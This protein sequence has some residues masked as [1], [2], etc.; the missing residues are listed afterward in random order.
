MKSAQPVFE[1]IKPPRLTDLGH[2]ALVKF[3][4]DRWQYEERIWE[5]CIG[6][7]EAHD[8]V[9][10]SIKSPMEPRILEHLAH[11]EFRTTVEEVTEVRLQED[12]KRRVGTLMNDHVPDVTGL[13][14]NSLKMDMK[15]ADIQAR[16]VKYFMDF[17]QLADDHG[18]MA[19]VGRGPTLSAL[20][21]DDVALYEL[22]VCRAKYQQHFHTMQSELKR[23]DPPKGKAAASTKS[24]NK[25]QQQI[26]T[27]G[28]AE[29]YKSE[30]K[31]VSAP[32]RTVCLVC[33]GPH[34]AKDSPDASEEMKQE[35]QRELQ[36]RRARKEDRAKTVRTVRAGEGRRVCVNGVL[37]VP[38]CPDTEELQGVASGVELEALNPV[39][40]VQVAGGAR[41][42]C[43]DTVM[44]DLRIETAAGPLHLTNVSCL[45]MDGHEDEFLLGRNTMQDIGIDIRLF[46][47]LAGGH[48][49]DANDDDVS[50]DIP[51]LAPELLSDLRKLIYEYAD[52][53]R[54]RI[55]ADPPADVEP[56]RV[57]LRDDAVPYRSG[58]KKY[59]PQQRQFFFREFV[60]ELEQHGLVR[61]N[62]ASHWA[63][64]ALPVKKP[65]SNEFRC[66]VDYRTPNKCTVPLPGA[67]PN[68]SSAT[69]SVKGA[70]GFGLV[71][72]FKG[73][74]QLPLRPDSQELFSFVT[75]DGVFTPTRLPQGTTTSRCIFSY[76]CNTEYIANVRTFLEVVRA[77]RL[78]LNAKKCVLF[79]TGVVWCGKVIDGQGV[80]HT[81][82]RLEALTGMA[83]PPTAA[84]LQQFLCTANWLRESMVDCARVVGPLQS[85]LEAVMSRRGRRKAQLTGVTLTWPPEDEAAFRAVVDLLATSAKLYFADPDAVVRDWVEGVPVT[86]QLHELLVC[87]GGLFTGSQVNW[88]IVEKEAYPVVRACSDLAY[89][90]EREKGV[91]IYCDHA[92]LIHIFS[93]DKTVKPHLRGKLQRWAL[94]IVGV[95]Y[96]IEHIKGDDNVWADLVSRWGQK[97]ATPVQPPQAVKRVALPVGD[98]ER[99][100]MTF[101]KATAW[102]F[103]TDNVA[104][105]YWQVP[106]SDMEVNKLTLAKRVT[107]RSTQPTS[108]LR[109][110]Q[111]K[112]FAWPNVDAV[113]DEQNRYRTD[114]L[115][116]VE[117][118][119]L[120]HV[121]DELWIPKNARELVQR[122][123]VVAHCGPQGHRGSDVIQPL[124]G[125]CGGACSASM[126]MVEKIVM[127]PWG[128]TSTAEK[129]NECLHMDY[130]QLRDSYGASRYVF[131]LKDELTHY[132]E[133]IAADAADSGTAVQAVLDWN[134]RFGLPEIWASDNGSHFKA[135]VMAELADRLQATQRFVP[136]YTPWINGTV[137]RV[138][139][140]ILQVL[141]VMLME[142]KLDTRNWVYLL[143]GIQANLN[144]SVVA[145]LGGHAPIEL[146]T[147]LPAPSLLDTMSVPNG[148]SYR[149]LPVD[150]TAAAPHLDKLREHLQMLHRDVVDRKERGRLQEMARSKG[151]DC[152]FEE[153]DYVLWS[154]VDNRMS[155]T[156]LLVR[157]VGPFR[158]VRALSHSFV[159]SHLLT[160]DEFE[161]HGSRLKHYC[162]ADLGTTAEIRE[163]VASQGI[164]LGV[165]AIVDHCYDATAKEWQL[166]VAWRGLEDEENSWE[167][168][169]VIYRD[170]PTLARQYIQSGDAPELA[171]ML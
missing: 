163:H 17:D 92:N 37:D 144:H 71:D 170:V 100:S 86:E 57:K 152:N 154:R 139:R 60:L 15:V 131:V 4:R 102:S 80:Q 58:T 41:I 74:W 65:H 9:L 89:L 97:S 113:R 12:I 29:R 117:D 2:H 145:S 128:P 63:C 64:P 69:Q 95:R 98:N 20:L 111:E 11:Y 169:A 52:V 33:K 157:W 151:T 124:I 23:D 76:S 136:V 45:V 47:Q 77:R 106:L 7:G 127:R 104:A 168:F 49:E 62:N 135:A 166:H 109:P 91:Q 129:R 142:L 84:A 43:R 155:G 159:V 40:P 46:E 73:F 34:W 147:G 132:C 6:T 48:V 126:L 16:V 35:I 39:I 122:L 44:L 137:E 79:D 143:P 96:T 68:L 88:S 161:V 32:P 138:N 83:L 78:K 14:S 26:K 171:A 50:G 3:V 107:T 108:T 22:I 165:R 1:Y 156:N 21:L 140:D 93:P 24:G 150:M 118:D 90:L 5:R 25:K 123:L 101:N 81:P 114:A 66:I 82:E 18:L 133:L 110:L 36:A 51:H 167:P 149:L 153:G 56:L 103:D 38:F 112:K 158:V 19:W 105:G 125:F 75:E 27:V 120:V 28:K 162:D 59:P 85:K 119:G 55:G 148:D 130:L 115:V 94:H 72:L 134:K 54:V 42:T 31:G 146:F 30:P 116:P 13:F 121:D 141:R 164:L 70:Y 53:W 87:R 99:E 8:T 10:V 160:N 61:R 67:T